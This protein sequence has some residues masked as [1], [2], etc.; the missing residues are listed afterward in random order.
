MPLRKAEANVAWT[1]MGVG[2][3][4]L[5]WP[6]A[7]ARFQKSPTFTDEAKLTMLRSIYDHAQF[8]FR[9]KTHLNHVLRESNGLLSLGVYFPEYTRAH[10]WRQR[11]L[12]RLADELIQHVNP[13]GCSVEMSTAYQW[14]VVDEFDGTREL[15]KHHDLRFPEGNLDAW[16]VKLYKA[17]AYILRPDGAWPRLDD[18]FMED[19]TFQCRRL[20]AAGER[21]NRPDIIYIASRGVRGARP[22]VTSI[23]FRDAGLHVMRSDWSSDARYLLLD[24]GP[25]AGPHGHEDKLNIEVCAYGTPFIVDPGC[26]TYNAND[27]YRGYFA[28]SRAHSTAVIAGK[29]QI[30]RWNQSFLHPKAGV[31]EPATWI[32]SREF[33]YGEGM[34]R[35]GY[36][37]FEFKKPRDA[38]VIDD[39]SHIRRVLFVKPDYWLVVDQL[40]ATSEAHDYEILF[41][42]DPAIKSESI[43]KCGVYMHSDNNVAG[44]YLITSSSAPCEISSVSGST[45]P[46]Q[47]WY[48]NGW[49]EHKLPTTTLICRVENTQSAVLATLLYPYLGER[50]TVD[51]QVV[52]ISGGDGLAYRVASPLGTDYLMFSLDKNMKTF[53]PCASDAAIVGF[54]TCTGE[55]SAQ[56][57]SWC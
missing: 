38:V 18:G 11:A 35:D 4:S 53:G 52:E 1:L 26:Y 13:D 17:L 3:R 57:F 23:A 47:G 50:P 46:I 56:L 37:S 40:K 30:R 39:A 43:S 12:S 51:F 6:A 20:A 55:R 22:E 28:S 19:D 15:L 45:N 8:L 5:I 42:L 16:L 24:T 41:N 2:I 33:D 7:F 54:R 34:Y 25:F 48:A 21:L 32:S 27:S 14:L 36:C 9:F 44:M 10:D 31:R 49:H 29:S